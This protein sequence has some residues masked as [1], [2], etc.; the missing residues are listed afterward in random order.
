MGSL[1]E[2]VPKA[3]L[4]VGGKTLVD[5]AIERLTRVGIDEISIAIGWKG[6]LIEEHLTSSDNMIDV[7]CVADYEIG[8]L[9]TLTTV[10]ETFDDDF[11]LIPVDTLTDSSVIADMLAQTKGPELRDM[12]LAVD[13]NT[14]SGTLVSTAEDGT[15]TGLGDGVTN[16]AVAHS[17]M[18]FTGNSSLAQYC[19]KSLETGATK[20]VS[21]LNQMIIDGHK[22]RY[23]VVNRRSIDV[24]TLSD[25]LAANRHI[26]QTGEFSQAGIIFVPSGDTMEI[27]DTLT[28]SS[29]TIIRGGSELIGPVLLAQGS[30]IGENCKI[31][32]NCTISPGSQLNQGCH[33]S[34]TIVFGESTIPFQSQLQRMV[35]YKSRIYAME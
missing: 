26:L 29:N 23:F 22:L 7:V 31:G 10:L 1:S 12:T 5:H 28:L 3:L 34:D 14:Q 13:F 20:L 11:L 16:D 30:D 4:N 25:L 24:D 21:M 15:I 33:L 8:P 18:V 2:E 32:P 6:S 27:G 35:V 9:Q 19:K 17:A